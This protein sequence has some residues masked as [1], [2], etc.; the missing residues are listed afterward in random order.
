MTD[1]L[2]IDWPG[3]DFIAI[4]VETANADRSSICQVGLAHFRDGRLTARWVRYVDPECDFD[5]G[6]IAIHGIRPQHVTGA[7]KIQS[8]MTA[9]QRTLSGRVFVSHSNFDSSALD[10]ACLRYGAPPLDCRWIDT[11]K[12]ARRTWPELKSNGGHSLKSVAGHIGHSFRHH[13]AL[14]DAI[15]CG[16]IFTRAV[17]ASCYG[18]E[19]WLD[20]QHVPP[21]PF[22]TPEHAATKK[23][24][25][26]AW[27]KPVPPEA[28][29]QGH[30]RGEIVVFTGQLSMPRADAQR[31]AA[32]AGCTVKNNVTWK[33]TIV[34]VGEQDLRVMAPGHTRSSKHRYA[35]QLRDEG[36]PVRIIGE[37][38][39]LS[40]ARR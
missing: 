3:L 17:E 15:A 23:R 26:P 33:T 22:A 7:P 34:V 24:L 27:D 9:L 28:N 35:M 39:F 2:G 40:L 37:D 19:E 6:N 38:E 21:E 8:L 12:V 13:D 20:L 31:I 16:M 30:L 29:A 4:D 5:Y 1:L 32:E 36:R 14:E 25:H 18:L 10:A 11:V